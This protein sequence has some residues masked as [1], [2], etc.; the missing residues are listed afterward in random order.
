MHLIILLNLRCSPKFRSIKA[1]GLLKI[2]ESITSFICLVESNR[3]T[4]DGLRK[5][6]DSLEYLLPGQ[7]SVFF[8]LT[9]EIDRPEK[10]SSDVD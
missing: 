6:P 3:S 2:F 9:V 1:Y 7:K 5:I 8:P 10:V 4:Y